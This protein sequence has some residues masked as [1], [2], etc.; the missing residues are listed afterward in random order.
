MINA[1]VLY[2]LGKDRHNTYLREAESHRKAGLAK[3]E[4]TAQGDLVK[5]G[6]VK[7]IKQVAAALGVFVHRYRENQTGIPTGN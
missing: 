7:S 3:R 6:L 4:D 2:E 5:F 1:Y